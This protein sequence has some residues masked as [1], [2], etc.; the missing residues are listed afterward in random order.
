MVDTFL[1][2]QSI[3]Q[4]KD[5]GTDDAAAFAYWTTQEKIAEHEERK[6]V[7]RGREIVKRYRDERPDSMQGT[8]RYNILWSN[9]QT[10]IP[11]LYGRTPAADVSRRFK[12][13]PDDAGRMAATLLETSIDYC[14]DMID[15]DDVMESIV[16][17]RLLP[18]RGV[19]RV[20]YIPT[21]GE[22]IASNDNPEFEDT[23]ASPD[24]VDNPGDEEKPSSEDDAGD[25]PSQMQEETDPLREVINEEVVIE[26][27]FWEDYR[28]GPARK[29]REV[30]WLRYRAYMDRDQLIKRFGA[31]GKKVNLDYQPK[32][33]PESVREEPPP[34]IYKKAIVWEIWDKV[35]KQVV[36]LAPGTPDLILDQID[37]PL[38]LKNFFPQP[39][40]LRSTTTNDKRQPVADYIE[41]QDQAREM[42]NLTARIDRLTRALKVS[43]VYP[44]EEKQV[45]QQLV[46]EG[47]ENRLIPV[48]D[49]PRWGDKGTLENLIQFMPIKQIAET[50]IQLY[51]AREKTKQTLYEITGIGDI[52]RGNTDPGETLGAQQLKANF[53]TRRITPQQKKVAKFASALFQIVGEV[54]ALHFDPKT[55]SK[56]TG[57]PVLQPVPQLP[58]PPPQMIPAPPQ[59]AQQPAQP[60]MP[61]QAA[62]GAPPVAPGSNVTPFPQQPAAVPNP[63]FAQWQQQ[64]QQVQQIVA[65]NAQLQAQ[66]DA[67]VK[68][69]KEDVK[70]GFRIDIEADSTIAADEQAEKQARTEFIS[71]AVPL[72]GQLIPM[73]Q[74]NPALA[75]AAKELFLFG[76]RAFKAARP[77]EETFEKAFDAIGKMPPAPPKG[78]KGGASGVDS[79]ADIALRAKQI[80]ADSADDQGKNQIAA[81]A[82][83][84]KA[85]QVAGELQLG[86]QKLQAEIAHNST[87]LSL[88]AQSAQDEANFRRERGMAAEARTASGLT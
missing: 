28:E 31:K 60:G 65:A 79:P 61:P 8:H 53:S 77:L 63:A 73:A 62:P 3:E 80:Q 18:G 70:H 68:L 81:Q 38:G 88:D 48:E 10:L 76:M 85:Q 87:K 83:A 49:W 35:K 51:D 56:M 57:H 27:V 24:I 32:G 37:D 1:A 19:A 78:K 33:S 64:Q 59:A 84:I 12:D 36:W 16:E 17:D 9:V 69:I 74:G 11:T 44:G 26:Y 86:Q 30:P 14:V 82:N 20:L 25:M 40:P 34:D 4:R 71:E 23:Q 42:D 41:Y 29:W 58:A 6:F 52:M 72:L 45:L 22:P 39:D 75:D 7:K 66:F 55:I 54:I 46:D 67:A 15:L 21:F 2:Q 5:L 43:G 47:T 13:Q 50:L